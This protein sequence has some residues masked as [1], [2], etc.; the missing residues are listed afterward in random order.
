[1]KTLVK[2]F[3]IMAVVSFMASCNTTDD[4]VS[5]DSFLKKTHTV[6]VPFEADLLSELVSFDQEDA[7]CTDE[8]YLGRVILDATGNATHMGNVTLTFNFCCLGPDDPNIPGED[9][10]YAG[11]SAVLVA[12]NGDKL[13]LC[14][15]GGTVIIG[16]TDD[17][18]EYVVDYWK[19]KITITGG[20]GRFEGAEGELQMDD[21]DTNIDEYSHHHWTG[22]ITLVKGK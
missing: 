5:N 20:T 21:F 22:E 14:L 6:T 1:M 2:F 18:P 9:N 10:K 17:H 12:A 11:S 15:E 8:G 19:D 3:F 4:P 7:Y 13:F 16:R